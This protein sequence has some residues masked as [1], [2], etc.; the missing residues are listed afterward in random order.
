[1]WMTLCIDTNAQARAQNIITR[2]RCVTA[3][4]VQ[5]DVLHTRTHRLFCNK[6]WQAFRF[7]QQHLQEDF[8]PQETYSVCYSH[9][10]L[11]LSSFCLCL[12]LC[13]C[14]SVCLSLCVS[15]CLCLSLCLS[16]SVCLSVS[17]CLCLSV[18]L[19]LCL[20]VCLSL[21]VIL[22]FNILL[23]RHHLLFSCFLDHHLL[24]SVTAVLWATGDNLMYDRMLKSHYILCGWLC[25]CSCYSC[26]CDRIHTLWLTLLLFLLQ[27]YVWQDVKVPHTLWL[28][29]LLFLS[30]LY[31]WQDVKV[32]HTLWLTLLLF[33][34]QL[35]VWQDPYF[36]ADFVTVPVTAVCVTGSILCGWLCYCS[37]Y[38]CMCDRMLKSHILCGWLCYCSCYSCMFDRMLKYILCGWLCYCSCHS[39]MFDRMLKY[40]LCGWLCYCSCHS[41]VFDRMLKSHIL[42]GWLCY[43][44]CHSCV[45]DRMFKSHYILSGWLCSCSCYSCQVRRTQ[46]TCGSSVGWARWCRTVTRLLPLS[47]FTRAP[48]H[49]TSSGSLSS[50][51]STWSV[52]PVRFRLGC[53]LQALVYD[54]LPP[55]TAI[56]DYAI[57]LKKH[58]RATCLRGL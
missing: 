10:S 7:I 1:M 36:V 44:S 39:C 55:T 47:A 17:L 5:M 4:A 56:V 33:L 30:Q 37:C 9:Y 57:G 32:P 26:M 22:F 14:L 16:L 2:Y 23:L 48:R 25:Y 58:W 53:K 19:C 13:L 20:S 29:L 6:I 50:A 24:S 11:S 45:F 15:L 51:M 52:A 31:V 27:L 46:L 28:T 41:C 34:L 35:Y 38:S 12:S 42:Y 3:D 49:C 54:M 40:I 18:S 8:T 21:F 43:C